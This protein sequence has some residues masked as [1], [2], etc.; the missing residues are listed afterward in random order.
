MHGVDG[1]VCRLEHRPYAAGHRAQ[2]T[3]VTIRAE[4]FRSFPFPTGWSM[5]RSTPVSQGTRKLE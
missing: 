3:F 4:A 5:I 2:V 1:S